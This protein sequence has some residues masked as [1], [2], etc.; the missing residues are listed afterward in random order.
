MCLVQPPTLTYRLQ[1]GLVKPPTL[2]Y[3]LQVGFTFKSCFSILL[4]NRTFTGEYIQFEGAYEKSYVL[5][6]SEQAQKFSFIKL[7]RFL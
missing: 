1:V 5:D 6:H 7:L 3:R 2:T 4:T